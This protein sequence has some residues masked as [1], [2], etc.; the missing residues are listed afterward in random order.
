MQSDEVF[1]MPVTVE[2]TTKSGK[3][4]VIIKPE[5]KET[6]LKIKSAR[7]DVMVVD[8]DDAILKEVVD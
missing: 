3:R 6:I 5:G 4:R 2:M 1:L 8:P 7:P